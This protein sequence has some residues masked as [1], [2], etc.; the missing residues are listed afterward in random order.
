[1]GQAP[2]RVDDQFVYWTDYNAM[3][4]AKAPKAGGA[5]T[6]LHSGNVGGALTLDEGYAYFF[7]TEK[8]ALMRVPTGGGQ[9]EVLAPASDVRYLHVDGPWL[10][11]GDNALSMAGML[12]RAP[13]TGGAPVALAETGFIAAVATDASAVYVCSSSGVEKIPL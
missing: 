2:L 6:I 5:K 4:L 9:P 10:Y 11:Y 1:M 7:S 3:E 8:S 13:K 12:Y